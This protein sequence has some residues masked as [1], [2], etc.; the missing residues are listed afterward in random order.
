[1]RELSLNKDDTNQKT[2]DALYSKRQQLQNKAQ[3]LIKEKE[4]SEMK[5]CTFIPKLISKNKFLKT[6]ASPRI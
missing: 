5:E 2:Y 6:K 4:V 1:M 3:K